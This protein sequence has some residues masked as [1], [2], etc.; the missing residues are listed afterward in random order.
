MPAKSETQRKLMAAAAH[1]ATFPKAR[2]VQQSMTLAQ[3]KEFGGSVQER[4][5]QPP[6]SDGQKHDPAHKLAAG[7][8]PGGTHPHANLGKFLHPKKAR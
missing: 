7:R 1:G 4:T 8:K 6:N 5:A 3:L 2:Q